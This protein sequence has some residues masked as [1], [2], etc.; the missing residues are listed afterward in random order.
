M[1]AWRHLSPRVQW[2][3]TTGEAF[4]KERDHGSADSSRRGGGFPLALAAGGEFPEW[5]GLMVEG[6]AVAPRIG[7][8]RHGLYMTRYH[9][10]VMTERPLWQ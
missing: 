1:A 6:K 4:G 8:Y 10:E 3:A 9:V 2:H 7:R 5:I